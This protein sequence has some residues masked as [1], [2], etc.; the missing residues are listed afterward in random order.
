MRDRDLAALEF[1]K[2]LHLLANNAV[3]SAGREACLATRPQ[4]VADQ[5]HFESERTWQ[6]FRLLEEQLSLP[7]RE[8]PDVRPAL[9][10]AAQVGASLEGSRLLEVLEVVALSRT[11][12]TFFH[13]QAAEHDHLDHL[14]DLPNRLLAFPELEDTLR[15][16]L[17][18]RGHLKD[19]ASPELRSLRRRSR[20]ASE[21]I[22]QRLQHLLRSSQAKDVIADHYITIRNNR[23]VIPVRTNFNL[24]LQG[25]VQDR[26]GS[27]ET[28]FIEPLFAVDLNNRL[29]LIRKEVEA[30]EQRLYLW[31]TELVRAEIP[32]LESAFAALI[33]VD[34]LHAKVILARKHRCSKPILGSAEV[35]VRRARHPLLLATGK[36]VT[37][38]DLLISE[39]KSGLIITGPNTGGKTAALKTLGL[40]CLMAQSG[41][42]IP[43]EE[44]S[45]L[46]FFSGIFA[47][48]GDAQSLEQSLS[49]FSAHVRNV[50]EI[51]G[52]LE[53]PALVLFDEPGGGTDPIEGGA[54]ACGL[55]IHLKERG[56]HV[57][58]STHLT[59]VKLFAL[60]D[61]A[62]QVAAV[63]F[64]L[65]TLTPHYQLLYDTVGQSLGLPMARR[66]GLPEAVCAAA[67]ATLSD[68]ERQLSSAIAQLEALRGALEREKTQVAREREEVTTLRAQQQRLLADIE[69]KKRRLWQDE[70]AEVK[71]LVRRVRE[72]GREVLTNLRAAQPHSRQQ[73]AKFLR[74]HGQVITAKE[75]MLQPVAAE[76]PVLPQVGDAVEL[77]EGKIRG[78]LVAVQGN[79]ARIRRGGM[80]FEVPMEQVRKSSEK[81][82]P[83]SRV[84]IDRS[85][86]ASLPELNL[87]GMRVHE[88]LPRLEEFLDRAVLDRQ[89]TV[90]IV[91]GLGTGALRRAVRE[92]LSDSPY[93][94]SFTEASRAE[95]G[96]GATV[97]E[98]VS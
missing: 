5:V 96:G 65:D 54:L 72:E 64:D 2:V 59:P 27:G 44:E 33:E 80:T 90:R 82:E 56:V 46:P 95:G 36:P 32:R 15:R 61:G 9:Q 38:I 74:E 62:Y 47:D 25:I 93:C 53:P 49:T 35:R 88:A 18:E 40:V 51:L 30:E 28:L 37:A 31:L 1:D 58:A 10:W 67:E 81:P 73:L 98:L 11:L 91:H 87:L 26:S 85:G 16:C 39:G 24:R 14:I 94:A 45:R 34:V 89:T 50:G 29:L 13:R 71:Q 7:L 19:E 66:L 92:F 68:E 57:A 4:T 17:D 48:I 41:L 70:L 20:L 78:E 55:L 83:I 63:A 21:E 12:S 8:F 79:R 22:E 43:A 52:E 69:D 60:A 84:Q 97:V 3:S 42:L 6:F 75:Q 86:G 76:N 77:Q 23:F